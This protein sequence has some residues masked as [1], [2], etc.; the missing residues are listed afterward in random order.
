MTAGL[1]DYLIIFILFFSSLLPKLLGSPL[2]QPFTL[3]LARFCL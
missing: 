1:A 3:P 2:P